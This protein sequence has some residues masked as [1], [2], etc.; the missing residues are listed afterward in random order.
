MEDH[1]VGSAGERGRIAQ[2][3]NPLK[4]GQKRI[5]GIF[6]F[7]NLMKVHCDAS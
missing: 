6:L 3:G 5:A 7:N 2:T 1:K 4:D